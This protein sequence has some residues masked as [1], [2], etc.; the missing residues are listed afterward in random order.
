MMDER[1]ANRCSAKVE[2]APLTAE[3]RALYERWQAAA[4]LEE[5]QVAWDRIVAYLRAREVR[6]G[7]AAEARRQQALQEHARRE[8][9]WWFL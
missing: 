2:E 5:R 1:E 6:V 8:R 4:T 7:S 3:L 9:R